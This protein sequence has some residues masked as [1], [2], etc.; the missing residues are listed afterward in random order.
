MHAGPSLTQKTNIDLRRNTRTSE[1]LYREIGKS[2]SEMNEE[3]GQTW[4]ELVDE[5]GR[6]S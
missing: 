6:L 3:L 1:P 5:T 4:T 2:K